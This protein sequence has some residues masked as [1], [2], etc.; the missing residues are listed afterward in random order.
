MKTNLIKLNRPILKVSSLIFGYLFWLIIAQ[1]QSVST[2]KEIPIYFYGLNKSLKI[3][4]APEAIKTTISG[5]RL[6]LSNFNVHE[7][8]AH[9]DASEI[10]ETGSISVE[11]K[12]EN[13]FLHNNYKLIN[14]WPSSLTI[15]IDQK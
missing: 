11:V 8:S 7:N 1:N 12:R 2:T 3:K 13:I 5:K 14:Y 4:N 10:A 9:V 6:D 15:Q